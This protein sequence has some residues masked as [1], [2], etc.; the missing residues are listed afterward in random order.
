MVATVDD[1]RLQIGDL[2]EPYLFDD[3]AIQQALDEASEFLQTEGIS[4]DS[5]MGTRAHKLQAAIFLVSAYLGRIKNRAIRSIREGDV[6]IDYIDLQNQLERW[7]AELKDII[8]KMQ[9]PAEA[10]YDNF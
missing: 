9:D 1:V 5:A 6:S 2:E 7:K 8:T 10:V 4:L 3:P